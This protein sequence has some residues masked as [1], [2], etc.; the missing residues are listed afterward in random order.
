[1]ND[2]TVSAVLGSVDPALHLS[3]DSIDA[4]YP[5]ERLE[6]R[7]AASQDDSGVVSIDS[8]ARR[9]HFRPA[10]ATVAV[11]VAAVAATLAFASVPAGELAAQHGVSRA[12]G[13]VTFG[14]ATGTR[15]DQAGLRAPVYSAAGA[16]RYPT[17]AWCRESQIVVSLTSS[18]LTNP[19]GAGWS[20]TFWFR[21]VGSN[22]TLPSYDISIQPVSGTSRTRVGTPSIG[23][24]VARSPFVIHRDQSAYANASI[25]P[26]D[27]PTP[28]PGTSFSP[29]SKFC[30]SRSSDGLVLN[31]YEYHWRDQYFRLSHPV[32]VC[33]DVYVNVS[34]GVVTPSRGGRS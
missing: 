14:S 5:H 24:L 10:A 20:G 16:S 29:I 17:V 26:T 4:L 8:P 25:S 28:G 9:R 23:D 1:M 31:G 33:T 2:D 21:N 19:A 30:S 34:A 15:N 13:N 11:G 18:N 32:S 6:A 27:A 3:D 22:C 12:S 7:I